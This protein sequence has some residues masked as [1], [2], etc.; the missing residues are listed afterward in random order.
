[1]PGLVKL[2]PKDAALARELVYGCTRM[3]RCLDYQIQSLCQRPFLKLKPVVRLALRMGAYQMLFLDAIPDHAAV[4]ESVNLVKYY[5]ENESAGFVNAILR[6]VAEKKPLPEPVGK[7]ELDTLGLKTSHPAWLLERWAK[8]FSPEE[9]TSLLAADN[10]PHSLY[11]RVRPGTRDG[12]MEA[13]AKEGYKVEP[14]SWPSDAFTL[15]GRGSGLF[16]SESFLRGDWLVQDWAAQ[17]MMELAPVE[18]GMRVW[19]VCAAPGGKSVGLHWKVGDAGNVLATD[20]SPIRLK[21]LRENVKRLELTGLRVHEGDALKI[22]AAEKFNLAWVDAPCSG[23]GVLS[24][25]ADLRWR[26]SAE[27]VKRHPGDQLRLLEEVQRRVYPGGYL[28]YST[29]SLEPE[30]NV[31]VAEAFLAKHPTFKPRIPT[32]PPEFPEFHAVPTGVWIHPTPRHDGGFL[33][34]FQRSSGEV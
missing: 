8:R 2:D 25:R 30:E 32:L 27:D 22:P 26:I 34:I 23:T 6:S 14:E 31:D 20:V 21:L 15:T 3:Q 28:V 5:G 4:H 18:A 17:A 10:H 1:M 13:L 16:E 12:V 11:M 7:D 19:D 33:A 24:R 9:L 29:C